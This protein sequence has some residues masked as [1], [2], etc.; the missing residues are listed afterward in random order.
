M[1]RWRCRF[2][3]RAQGRVDRDQQ[4]GSR[5]LLCD[6]Q[7]PARKVLRAEADDVTAALARIQQQ[8]ERQP[9]ARADQPSFREPS[10]L[11]LGPRNDLAACGS[12][13]G[14]YRASGRGRAVRC[15]SRAASAS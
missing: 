13:A 10:D 5:L 7:F 14:A 15:R 3:Q 1:A 4:F 11:L 9:R 12:A 2:E 6:S 8:V